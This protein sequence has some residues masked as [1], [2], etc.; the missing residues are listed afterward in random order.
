MLVQTFNLRI[1]SETMQFDDSVLVQF[2]REHEVL[3]WK[4][5]FF[6]YQEEPNFRKWLP[7]AA[8]I[9]SLLLLLFE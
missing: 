9:F 5:Q 1:D 6:H 3:S 2:A 7:I 8:Q 4:T